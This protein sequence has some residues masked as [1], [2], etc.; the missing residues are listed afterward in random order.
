MQ[1]FPSPV[2]SYAS[3]DWLLALAFAIS[4][5]SLAQSKPNCPGLP[6]AARLK[7]VLQSVVKQGAS[8]NG[9]MGN[10]E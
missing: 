10:Q 3:L 1:S 6:T 5:P 2:R 7:S 9:G 4:L 8:K